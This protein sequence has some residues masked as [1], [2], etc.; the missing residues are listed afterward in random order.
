MKSLNQKIGIGVFWN[1]VNLFMSRGAST[2][3]ML[4]LARFLAPEAFGLIAM[5]SIAFELANAL[6]NSGLG[7][8]LIRSKEVTKTDLSTVFYSNIAISLLCYCLLFFAAP[9]IS[10]FYS[11]PELTALLRVMG[12]VVFI[13]AANIVQ[14]VVLSRKM[15]FR[16]QMKANTFG[17]IL[18][19]LIASIAAWQGMGVWSLVLQILSAA[20]LT[21]LLFWVQSDWR[22]ALLF[23]FESFG[24]LFRFGKNLLAEGVLEIIF[25]NSYV[26]VIGRFFSAEVTGL[27]FLAKKIN[28]FVSQNLT[29]AV[30][31]ATFPALSTLQ[32][33]NVVLKANYRK[34]M[35]VMIFTISPV[36]AL[37]GGLAPSI[38]EVAFS[39]SWY[40]AVPY[41][42]LLCVA[43]VIYPLHALNINLLNVKGRSDLIL[44][45]G[46][47]K[48]LVSVGFLVVS[49]PYGVTG[50]VASQVASSIFALLPNTYYSSSLIGYSLI[51]QV[52]DVIKPLS[53]A[54]VAGIAVS[55]VGSELA[56][57]QFFGLLAA[58]AAG[59]VIYLAACFLVKAEGGGVLWVKVRRM[60]KV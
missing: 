53:A 44:K 57:Y 37:L 43:G 16:S 28:G 35:Q 59:L 1:L 10:S 11:Q 36:M 50:V 22:P 13:N 31:Q 55:F 60:I 8:A 3:F 12:L 7:T 19:G 25:Q 58:L 18:S 47:L 2:I 5:A 48:K 33:D 54:A 26:L 24:R 51:E 21:T 29:V 39:S 46:I 4:F 30:Q 27:Y 40:G 23:S 9:L 15:D 49:I 56:R 17:A 45:V 38:F 32:D 41:L 14:V 6:V 42:Q 20:F 34:I 52:R